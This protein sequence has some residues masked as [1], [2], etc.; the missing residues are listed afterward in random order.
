[1]VGE[2]ARVLGQRAVSGKARPD[3]AERGKTLQ[4]IAV[5]VV[6]QLGALTPRSRKGRR[7]EAVD[8][9]GGLWSDLADHPWPLGLVIHA[10][11][12]Q[13][14]QTRPGVFGPQPCPQPF[15]AGASL[16]Q[17]AGRAD[18]VWSLRI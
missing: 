15:G 8:I 18:S 3:P 17:Y 13:R 1:V 5:R 10:G 14:P 16:S 12:Q 7:V 11:K 2:P 4:A 9:P 6:P